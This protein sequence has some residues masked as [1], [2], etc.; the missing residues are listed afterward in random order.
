MGAAAASLLSL[1]RTKLQNRQDL[2]AVITQALTDQLREL[3]TAIDFPQLQVTTEPVSVNP[4]SSS[5]P[6]S[7]I[8]NLEQ[9]LYAIV[10]ITDVTAPTA[11]TKLTQISIREYD[12]LGILAGIPSRYVR[13]GTDLLL[14]AVVQTTARSYRVRWRK[15]HDAV[16]AQFFGGSLLANTWDEVIATGAALRVAR[17]VLKDYDQADELEKQMT[18]MLRARGQLTQDE[19]IRDADFGMQIIY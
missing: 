14:D 12:R 9:E 3:S 4:S 13:F 17:D 5:I 11:P 1:A 15:Y 6:V 19:E 8:E 2:D 16:D 7:S 10:D 18:R